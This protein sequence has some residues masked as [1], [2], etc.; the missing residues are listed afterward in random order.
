MQQAAS[1]VVRWRLDNA[2]LIIDVPPAEWNESY[3]I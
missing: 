3:E 2:G 1:S